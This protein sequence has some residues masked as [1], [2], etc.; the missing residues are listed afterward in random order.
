MPEHS[1]SMVV[2]LSWCPREVAGSRIQRRCW[3]RME[4]LRGMGSS[5]G[6]SMRESGTNGRGRVCIGRST[7]RPRRPRLAPIRNLAETLNTPH[8]E[9]WLCRPSRR[10]CA[11]ACTCE[12][13][14]SAFFMAMQGRR[15][16]LFA[17]KESEVTYVLV[18]INKRLRMQYY[19]VWPR[20][21]CHYRD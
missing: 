1:T 5:G 4:K 17:D 6:R 14:T 18:D 12:L 16:R 15:S 10:Q 19:I 3:T 7:D 2:V 21:Y 11:C 13:S 8:L 20:D 9:M